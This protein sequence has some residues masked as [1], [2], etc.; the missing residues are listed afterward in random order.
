MSRHFWEY[1]CWSA[2]ANESLNCGSIAMNLPDFL[3][4]DRYGYIHVAEHR[5][6]IDDIVLCYNDGFSAEMLVA[7]YPTLTL[8]LIHKVLGFYLENREAIDAYVSDSV[9]ACEEQ[10]SAAPK[11]PTLNELRDRLK[12]LHPTSTSG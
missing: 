10:R 2:F 11:G 9:R 5:I 8:A 4:Q 1:N 7:Q 12:S 6:G 3:Q